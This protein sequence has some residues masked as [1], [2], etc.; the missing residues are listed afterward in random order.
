MERSWKIFC[1]A[2]LLISLV[3]LEVWVFTRQEPLR[4]RSLRKQLA[5]VLALVVFACSMYIWNRFS[6][7]IRISLV[8]AFF[9]LILLLIMILAQGV[10]LCL[11][12][13]VQADP[14]L[15]SFLA[16]FSMGCILLMTSSMIAADICSFVYRRICCRNYRESTSTDRKEMKIRSLLSL[17]SALILILGGTLVVNNLVIEHVTVPIKGLNLQM[18]GT[19]IV[20]IS[21]IHL[22]PFNGRSTLYSVVKK[23]N[24]LNGDIVVITG[25]LVDSSVKALKNSVIPLKLLK[26]KYGVYFITGRCFYLVC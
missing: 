12:L 20:Q 22:G 6:T 15:L 4:I 18:N 2:G 10:T 21:D 24:S 1:I 5:V 25:D 9:K 3:F 11:L 7:L 16:T 19:T 26:A 13:S 14:P 23:V 17:I 8:G